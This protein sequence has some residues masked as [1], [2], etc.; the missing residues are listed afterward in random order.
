MKAGGGIVGCL[1][2]K[3]R[4]NHSRLDCPPYTCSRSSHQGESLSVSTLPSADVPISIC[5]ARLDA[6]VWCPAPIASMRCNSKP[7]VSDT[8]EWKR[9]GNFAIGW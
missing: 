4:C 3:F 6:G 8:L 7:R 1:R 9:C 5:E 2:I